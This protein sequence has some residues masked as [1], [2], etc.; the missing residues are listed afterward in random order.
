MAPPKD[1]DIITKVKFSCRNNFEYAFLTVWQDC[2]N[3]VMLKRV[4]AG[5]QKT[6]FAVELAESYRSVFSEDGFGDKVYLRVARRGSRYRGYISSDGDSWIQTGDG[7]D[8]DL[9]C[10]RVGLGACAPVSG[11]RIEAEFEFFEVRPLP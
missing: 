4:F 10:K 1:W 9:R 3:Y 11:A 5:E 7:V 8:A 2:N 6:E